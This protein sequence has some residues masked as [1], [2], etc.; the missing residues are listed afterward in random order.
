[1][2]TDTN[3]FWRNVAL[4]VAF[5]TLTPVVLLASLISLISINSTHKPNINSNLSNSKIGI[6]VYASLPASVPSVTGHITVADARPEIVRQ[7]LSY[8]HSPLTSYANEIVEVADK[9]GIDYR[10]IPAIAQQ[11][12]NLCRIIP[13]GSFNCWGWGITSVSSLGFDSYDEGIRTVTK[14]LK[15][16]YI[17]EGLVTPN[18]IMTKYTPQSNGSW[19]RGVNEFMAQMQ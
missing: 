1:M 6:S 8:Y 15:E 11:E 17:D 14:G 19:A 13:E 18:Q 5:F 16:H 12:S 2:E 7:Y 9:Y 4:V 10:F 3:F